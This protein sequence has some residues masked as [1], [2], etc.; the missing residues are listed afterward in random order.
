MC[1]ISGRNMECRIFGKGHEDGGMQC[2][3]CTRTAMRIQSPPACG[4]GLFG[5]NNSQG[6]A[7]YRLSTSCN[8][9]HFHV[10]SFQKQPQLVHI[11]VLNEAAADAHPLLPAEARP[12]STAKLRNHQG[13]SFCFTA[14]DHE[15]DEHGK[16]HRRWAHAVA[17]SPAVAMSLAPFYAAIALQTLLYGALSVYLYKSVR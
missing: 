13:P 12:R 15:V 10:A 5:I 4:S 3:W 14:D 8:H 9:V 1:K 16:A 6:A 11:C 2:T 7:A 17:P